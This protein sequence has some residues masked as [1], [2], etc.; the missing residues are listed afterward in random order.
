M[1]V[2]GRTVIGM[3]NR[4][5]VTG[6]TLALCVT[7]LAGCAQPRSTDVAA[8]PVSI[9]TV[10]HYSTVESQVRTDGLGA[11][12]YLETVRGLLSGVPHEEQ[13]DADLIQ[14]GRDLCTEI[15]NGATWDTFAAQ[16]DS[17]G[18]DRAFYRVVI[19]AAVLS[20]CIEDSDILR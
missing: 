15:D 20:F 4:S 2:V 12:H 9:A 7:A 19:R 3:H 16:I 1:S 11:N 8:E 10:G 17:I 6:A 14:G 18:G 5:A 13:A